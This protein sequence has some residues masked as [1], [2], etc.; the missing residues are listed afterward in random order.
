[1]Q[2]AF[3]EYAAGLG[4]KVFDALGFPVGSLWFVL[5]YGPKQQV[6]ALSK[7]VF[8]RVIR[9]VP[10]LR[11]LRPIMRTGGVALT[12]KLPS[13]EPLSS[14]PQVAILDGGLPSDHPLERWVN[15][16]RKMDE[17]ADDAESGPEH[18]LGVTSAFLFGPITPGTEARRPFSFVDHLR[19]LDRN[20]EEEDPLELY[21]TLGFIEE[22]LLAGQYEFVNLSLGPNLPIEDDDVHA[23]TAVIDNLL[24]DGRVLMTVA[25]GNNGE[26]DEPSGNARVQV[27]GDCVNALSVGA[28]ST[29]SNDWEKSSYSALGPG[30]MPG[31]IKPDVLAFGGSAKN[32]FHVLSPG[33]G[34]VVSPNLGTSFAAPYLLRNAAGIRAILGNE[35]TALAIKALLIH[36]T[37]KNEDQ[38]AKSVG[39]GK[40]P[41]DVMDIITCKDGVARVVYQGALRPGTYLRAQLPI[42]AGGL[43]GNCKL[44]ATFC[45][46]CPVDPQ[47]A[48]A[49]TRAALEVTFRRDQTKK[50][51]TAQNA[52]SESFFKKA[53][54][55][56]EQELRTGTSKWENVLHAEKS[57]QGSKL[58]N[59]VFDI[60]YIARERGADTRRGELLPY[61]LI[62]SIEAPNHPTL[63]NDIL[64]TYTKLSHIQPQVA[65][66][67][68]V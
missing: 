23:W 14:V 31:V 37:E 29:I 61:A 28:A 2:S 3:K 1:M 22:V 41:D 18:G 49:Y 63:F 60:H 19:V 43:S 65:L 59:P 56:T 51:E 50:A 55:A 15:S 21:S 9:N 36:C 68:S 58:N 57:L 10:K 4:Y 40:T 46:A 11:G 26:L 17:Q 66:P 24:R 47:D 64:Q 25:V 16:Y 7:F 45:Y 5:L 52:N 8:M 44:K 35:L 33:K 42:P 54:F 32:Y 27:P 48:C 6:E 13:A 39:W 20:S 12:C 53:T 38:E 34:N 30:R 67:V 62:L